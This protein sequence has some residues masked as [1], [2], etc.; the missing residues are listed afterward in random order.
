MSVM[1]DKVS[2]FLICL[3]FYENSVNLT[4]L[5]IYLNLEVCIVKLQCLPLNVHNKTKE[6]ESSIGIAY[7]KNMRELPIIP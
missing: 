6:Q 3:F 4:N 2:L 7:T 5:I 1:R